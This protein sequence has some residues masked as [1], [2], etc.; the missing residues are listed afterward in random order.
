MLSGLNRYKSYE[1]DEEGQLVNEQHTC[2]P[3]QYI[4][5]GIGTNCPTK[6]G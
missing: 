1:L 6:P 2:R 3:N 5:S 4:N